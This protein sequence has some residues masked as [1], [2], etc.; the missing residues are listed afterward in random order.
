M[1]SALALVA[2]FIAGGL[3]ALCTYMASFTPKTGGAAA[4]LVAVYMAFNGKNKSRRLLKDRL[5]APPFAIIIFIL[6]LS[7]YFAL[8]EVIKKQLD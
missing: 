2:A 8:F 7:T 4:V 3:L 6:G 5:Y 1:T